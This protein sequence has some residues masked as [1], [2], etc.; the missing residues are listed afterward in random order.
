M[1]AQADR[2][3]DDGFATER[4]P[5]VKPPALAAEAVGPI[6]VAVWHD[7][8][9]PD[10]VEEVGRLLHC[11]AEDY[12]RGIGFV[13]VAQF[14]AP[15]PSA[16]IR[17]RIVEI[18]GE[19]GTS[20]V[21]VAQVVEGSGFWASAALCFIAGLGLLHRHDHL[22]KVFG[23]TDDAADWIGGIGVPDAPQ[24]L[25]IRERIQVRA[26]TLETMRPPPSKRRRSS[27]EL[28]VPRT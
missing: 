9:T 15:I 6:V 25:H 19:L 11:T 26:A 16:A 20:L 24:A 13:T 3:L 5:P 2:I 27:E 22:M 14:R 23:S 28:Q 12:P 10:A 7:E 1:P 18:Y 4:M 8:V 17:S 21:G